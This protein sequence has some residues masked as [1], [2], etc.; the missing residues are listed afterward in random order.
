MLFVKEGFSYVVLLFSFTTTGA[1][2][3]LLLVYIITFMN[4]PLCN[5]KNYN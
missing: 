4:S 2:V 5:E 3:L 1:V